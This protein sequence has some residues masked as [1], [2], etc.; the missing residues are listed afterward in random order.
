MATIPQIKVQVGEDAESSLYR[1]GNRPWMN[2][3][4]ILT[5]VIQHGKV[6]LREAPDLIQEKFD[7]AFRAMGDMPDIIIPELSDDL[8][9]L[10]W[11]F[12]WHSSSDGT[13]SEYVMAKPDT[14]LYNWTV[15]PFGSAH[16][17]EWREGKSLIDCMNEKYLHLAMS[18][19]LPFT[20]KESK[21]S[22]SGEEGKAQPIRIPTLSEYWEI[23]IK[24]IWMQDSRFRLEAMPTE[25]TTSPDTPAFFFFDR[26]KLM[27]GPHPHWDS[28]L[29]RM[30]EE[31]RPVFRAWIYSIF[32]PDNK[33]RQMVWL[34]DRGYS[35]KSSVFRAIKWYM[36]NQGVA[37]ISKNSMSDKFS[38]S[39]LFGKRLVIYGDTKNPKLL[40]SEKIH[41]LLGGDPVQVEQKHKA[42]FTAELNP[43]LLVASNTPPEVDLSA[44]NEVTRIIF[45]PLHE[46]P[47]EVMKNYCK[48]DENGDIVRYKDGTP[49]FIGGNLDQLLF[50][51]M[52]E[53]LHTCKKDYEALCPA[54]RDIP[55]PDALWNIL[56]TRCP[57]P[58][59]MRM[60]GFM[61]ER[62]EMGDD[63]SCSPMDLEKAFQEYCKGRP[64]SFEMGKLNAYLETLGCKKKR[65]KN[66]RI[67][68]GVMVKPKTRMAG[69]TP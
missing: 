60:E 33:G 21:D 43:R 69:G 55:L 16:A 28:W 54:R 22:A 25:I 40:H 63:R 12:K 10:F 15:D 20:E 57:S 18:G 64:T 50:E 5:F 2:H 42:A 56:H 68:E 23:H 46:P 29:T 3:E 66:K 52:N 17:I 49:K 9:G 13:R 45:I 48:L 67:W 53:F 65:K 62:L 8:I 38:Y 30:T 51:E 24:K 19:K 36:G 59:H 37:S 58:E 32:D 14:E 61:D 31:A 41:S 35:G 27:D 7:N 26:E 47:L 39:Q 1:A 6:S 44:R 11:A 34:Q 4:E